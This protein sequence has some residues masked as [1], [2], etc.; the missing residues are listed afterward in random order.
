MRLSVIIPTLGRRDVL[1]QTL[2]HLSHQTRLP[3]RVIITATGPEDVSGCKL[4][5][6]DLVFLFGSK[7]S[8]VQRNRALDAAL[9]CS[10]VISFFDDDFLACP[11]YFKDLEATFEAR[12]DWSVIGGDVIAD[13]A[14]T[15][16][17]TFEEGLSILAEYVAR[18]QPD[19][20][21]TDHPGA[22]GC[23]MSI[24]ACN[25]GDLRFDERLAL[26]GW[27]ED[28]DFTAQLKR[29]GRI[30]STNAVY[31]VHLGVK[32]GR[33]SGLRLGYSQVTNPIYLLRKGTI[34]TVF[35]LKLLARNFLANVVRSVR[36][37][38]WVDRRGR[39]R[40]N[41]LAIRHLLSG[42][43]EPEYVLQL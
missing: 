36:P 40:G 18:P 20:R 21:V 28:I 43:V 32:S 19:V 4:D 6:V 39:L 29:F 17:L 15:K 8:C 22:Y 11:N 10:D 3:D 26:Y 5:G 33:V 42:R 30:V 14:G 9:P 1:R 37:E 24:R 38:P 13:G 41:L 27:Q 25:V 7:G 16:G 12:P 31:G 35:A 34:P 2:E 23:N